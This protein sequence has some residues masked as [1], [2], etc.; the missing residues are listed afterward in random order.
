MAGD[1][2]Y[3]R[4]NYY[5][6]KPK[7][8]DDIKAYGA[9]IETKTKGVLRVATQNTNGT[10]VGNVQSGAEKISDKD[11]L[12]IDLLGITETKLNPSHE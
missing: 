7:A 12:G 1:Y 2:N 9:S 10:Q 4:I 11:H 5:L 3:G 8:L 6:G